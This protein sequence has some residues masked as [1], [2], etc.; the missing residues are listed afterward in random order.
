MGLNN[1]GGGGGEMSIEGQGKRKGHTYQTLLFGG[2]TQRV[3]IKRD[4]VE[5]VPR[6]C[7]SWK[8]E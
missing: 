8:E 2:S 6:F 4:E 5:L 1:N 3:G 7:E